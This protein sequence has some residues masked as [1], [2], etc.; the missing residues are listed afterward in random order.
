MTKK[1]EILLV[2]IIFSTSCNSQVSNENFNRFIVKFSKCTLPISTDDYFNS[3]QI[4]ANNA[5]NIEQLEY[6][7]YLKLNDGW[8]YEMYSKE[9]SS[10]YNFVIGCRFDL[11]G[12]KVGLLYFRAF[13]SDN[14]LDEKMELILSIFNNEGTLIS[15]IPI[16]GRYGDSFSFSSIIHN[17]D[18]IEINYIDYQSNATNK[19]TKHYRITQAG[20][21][22]PL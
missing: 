18:D 17:S 7:T 10:Y 22:L 14:E 12:N 4:Y 1:I 6:N 21:I 20:L 13:F 16:S 3:M 8:K 19:Y 2:I 9:K 11:N 5:C 15:H